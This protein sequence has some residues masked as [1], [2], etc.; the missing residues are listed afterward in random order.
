MSDFAA[1]TPVTVHGAARTETAGSGE[2]DYERSGRLIHAFAAVAALGLIGMLADS[3][4]IVFLTVPL[5]A[6]V[7]M[8]Q[9]AMRV[10][11]VWDRASVLAIVA[12]CA[13]LAV[14]VVWAIA[15][16]GSDAELWGLPISMGVIFYFIWP[17]TAG[18]AGL[19]YAFVFDR[20]LADEV[21]EA[22]P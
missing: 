8:L 22:T 21:V 20:T 17:Y 10:D 13:G 5:F 7:M 1:E 18:V 9:G 14:M 15:V 2:V 19:L 3:W 6:V 16:T 12:Y 4:Q 11:G